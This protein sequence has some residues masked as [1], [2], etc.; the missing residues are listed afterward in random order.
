MALRPISSTLA[1]CSF[2]S[3]VSRHPTGSSELSRPSGSTLSVIDP[4]PLRD[5]TPRLC[6]ISPS[7]CFRL[8]PPSLQLQL[9]P[10]LLWL[11]RDLLDPCLCLGHLSHQLHLA[12]PDPRHHPGS[13][14]LHLRPGLPSLSVSPLVSSMTPPWI[15]ILFAVWI[16]NWLLLFLPPSSAPWFP[17]PIPVPCPSPVLYPSP[18]PP[19]SL[20]R[21]TFQEGELLSQL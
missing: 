4:R 6:L 14:A 3:T 12:P 9:G 8:A 21:W 19:P 1:L 7:L 2:V 15:A 13:A 10:L 5:S 17:A 18:E 16:S 20:L 11:Y